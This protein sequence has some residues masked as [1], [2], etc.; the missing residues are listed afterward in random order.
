MSARDEFDEIAE[1]ICSARAHAPWPSGRLWKIDIADAFRA[2][3]A[4]KSCASCQHN[5]CRTKS[6]D[7]LNI[8]SCDRHVSIYGGFPIQQREQFSCSLY[9]KRPE[10]Q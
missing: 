5:V 8:E 7:P 1:S 3:A 9:A 2:A 10:G 6:S 4:A